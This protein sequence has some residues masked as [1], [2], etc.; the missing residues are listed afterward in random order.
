MMR[1]PAHV[2][3]LE[4]NW[5]S[6]NNLLISDG[7]EAA[8]IDSGY[9]TQSAQTVALVEQALGGAALTTLV[10]THLHSDHC[11]GNSA[12][13]ERFPAITTWVPPGQ[14]AQVRDWD[15]V[16]LTYVPT[17]Q[18]CPRFRVDAALT[19]GSTLR[20]GGQAWEVHAAPGHDPH[21]VILFEPRSRL[22]VSADALW[23]NG[24][25][26]VFPELDGEDAFEAVGATLDLIATLRPQLVVPG[27]GPAFDDVDAAL[28]RA[29]SRLASL[30]ADPAKHARHGAKVLMKF[31]LLQHQQHARD[32]FLRW[33][34]A[35]PYLQTIRQRWNPQ[36]DAV[37]WVLELLSELERAGAAR[38]EAGWIWNA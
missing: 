33:A 37:G 2:T 14:F 16:A 27:H 9:V 38:S 7:R 23:N 19:P 21:S 1:L 22:L 4:R 12:L 18:A 28:A 36:S 24:F 10:N 25:G 6:S 17:G 15:P 32:E 35:T 8:L 11:G 20:L 26:V 5:L 34:L 13:Q 31:R 3:L 29:R 30:T